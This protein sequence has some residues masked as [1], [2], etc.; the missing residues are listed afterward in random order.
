MEKNTK[1]NE[2]NTENIV[3]YT[4]YEHDNWVDCLLEKLSG[5]N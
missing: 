5:K 1:K 2:M 3:K 4:E